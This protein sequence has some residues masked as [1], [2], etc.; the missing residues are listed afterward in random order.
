[1]DLKYIPYLLTLSVASLWF[2]LRISKK[3]VNSE[4][5]TRWDIWVQWHIIV[6]WNPLLNK[7]A[8]FITHAWGP[9]V[10]SILSIFLFG[11]LAYKKRWNQSLIVLFS[12]SGW[13]ILQYF[14]K[15]L[16]QRPRP[17]NALI[18]IPNNY[19]F[20]SGHAIMAVIFFLLLIY[21]FKDEMKTSKIRI[22]F[23]ILNIFAFLFI[24]L[25]RI[26]LNVHW[27]SDVLAGFV[28]GI[29]WVTF[30]I[31]VLRIIKAFVWKNQSYK[32]QNK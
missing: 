32:L 25:S 21:I 27:M 2:F 16:I 22:F 7:I 12:I 3:I 5:I 29:I 24:G 10:L 31:L 8:I 19:S 20:P 23:I 14:I 26:Y 28:L 13:W 4:S 17:E 11:F 18:V 15:L 9:F 6:F 30:V 1:M